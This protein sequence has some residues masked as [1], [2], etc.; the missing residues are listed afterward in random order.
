MDNAKILWNLFHEN[1]EGSRGN[2]ALAAV[3]TE[4]SA[5][6]FRNLY[7]LYPDF[8]L[9]VEKEQQLLTEHDL[10]V[11]QHPFYWY[12]TPSLMKEWEDKV[13]TYGFA[14]PPK[15]GKALHGKKWLSVI[16]T[17]GPEWSYRSGGYNNFTISELLRPIQQTAYLCGMDWLPPF[18]V[19]GVIPGDYEGITA[20]LD[21]EIVSKAHELKSWL[22]TLDFK[23][24]HSLEP[25][26]APHYLTAITQSE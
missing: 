24:R 23:K 7:Q 21:S 14:Y 15:E 6:T 4:L 13:L 22:E 16:T 11:F 26:A 19:H 9:D 20:T 8:K 5:V 12:S 25:V 18:M 2:K 1:I 10:V 17:G 3:A